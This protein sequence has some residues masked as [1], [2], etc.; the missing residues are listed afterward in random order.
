MKALR[1]KVHGRVQGVWFRA[2]AQ[3]EA[4]NLGVNGWVRNTEDG[5]VEIHMQGDGDA[6]DRLLAWCYQ[7]PPGARVFQVDVDDVKPVET[8]SGFKIVRY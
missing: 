2:S 5:A 8:L 7:G 6:I 1:V 3:S 4:L